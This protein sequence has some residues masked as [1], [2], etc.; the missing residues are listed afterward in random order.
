MAAEIAGVA[1]NLC[2]L[3]AHNLSS[4]ILS[5][6]IQLYGRAMAKSNGNKPNPIEIQKHLTGMDYP[7]NK[8]D[9]VEHARGQNAPEEVV[10]VLESL[11]D[12]DYDKPTDVTKAVGDLE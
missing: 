11:P 6:Y 9:L 5:S 10:S 7:A 4:F 3:Q 1:T 12:R 2:Q 8:G